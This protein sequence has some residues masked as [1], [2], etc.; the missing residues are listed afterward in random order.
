MLFLCTA[1]VQIGEI[2]DFDVVT[3]NGWNEL[4][5]VLSINLKQ[6]LTDISLTAFMSY[7]QCR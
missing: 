7:V 5:D 6:V 4:N 3:I 1:K 2:W